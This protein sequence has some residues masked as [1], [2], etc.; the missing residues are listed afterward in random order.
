MVRN[1][2]LLTQYVSALESSALCIRLDAQGRVIFISESLQNRLNT[3]QPLV[4]KALKQFVDPAHREQLEDRI[5]YTVSNQQSWNGI[6]KL[7]TQQTQGAWFRCLTIPLFDAEDKLSEIVLLLQD[8]SREVY[9]D[10]LLSETRFDSV[11]GLATRVD[12]LNDIKTTNAQCLA[13]LDIRK[14]RSFADFYG[15][16]FGDELLRAFSSWSAQFLNDRHLKFYRLYGDK[17]AIVADFRMI[18]SVFEMHLKHY[19]QALSTTQFEIN[20]GDVAIDIALGMG[21][22]RKKL[23][24]LAESALTKAKKVF[25]GDRIECVKEREFIN[26]N[27][28]NWMPKIQAALD[29]HDFINYYQPIKSSNGKN[30]DYFE[31]LVRMRDDGIDLPP[32]MFLDKAKTTRYYSQITRSVIEQAVM[33]SEQHKVA[34]S[35]NISIEDI[36]N[37]QTVEFML[38]TLDRHKSAQLIFEI[39]E[40]ESTEDF[41][42][43]EDFA[44]QVRLRNGKIAIDDFGVGYSNFSRLIQLHPDY[45]K[46][47]GSIIRNI[48]S[49]KSNASILTGMIS[50]CREMNIPMVA[51]FVENE[52]VNGYLTQQEIEFLQGYYI[53]KPAPQLS[54]WLN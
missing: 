4:G 14:F 38:D 45:L 52:A 1:H 40:T 3:D 30:V 43:V 25:S 37:P 39:T 9:L 49:D 47:D 44:Q 5:K 54:K 18:P 27:K 21:V 42:A 16:E 8:V 12:L 31:A 15:L 36:L 46:I 33:Q 24:Q 2:H 28:V 17:F 19:Y 41:S 11:T 35:V 50:I 23:V 53:G 26:S 10:E 13:I 22:G 7:S 6:I 20:G 48:L 51:E 34:I 29:N 32:G